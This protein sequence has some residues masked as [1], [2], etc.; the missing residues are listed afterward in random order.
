MRVDASTA[1]GR[2]G[3]PRLL[4]ALTLAG[5]ASHPASQVPFVTTPHPVVAE[6]LRLAAVG[7]GDVVYDLGSGDGRLVVAAAQGF[8]AR[9]VGI[10]IEPRLVAASIASARRAGVADRVRFV[11]QDLFQADLSPATVVTL[12]LTRELNL[13]LRPKLLRELRPGARVVSHDFDMGDWQPARTIRVEADGQSRPVYLW[14]VPA[15]P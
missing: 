11:Q 7:P 10:E 2:G 15:R 6:M 13:R 14:V 12:Y 1:P 4:L 9:G 3:L 5:C 8:G